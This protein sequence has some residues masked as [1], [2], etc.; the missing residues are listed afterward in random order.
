MMACQRVSRVSTVVRLSGERRGLRGS[1][2]AHGQG[3]VVAHFGHLY[4][5]NRIK[6]DAYATISVMG[7]ESYL[8][9]SDLATVDNVFPH[10]IEDRP[11][12]V[13]SGILEI[14]YES[15]RI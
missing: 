6:S 10:G 12:L 8:P 13:K 9:H 14:K 7:E 2:H 4:T 15:R 5:G 1:D 3:K 11:R